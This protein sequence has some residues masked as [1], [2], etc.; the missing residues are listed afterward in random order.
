MKNLDLKRINVQEMNVNEMIDTDGGGIGAW[1]LEKAVELL[2]T[3][4]LTNPRDYVSKGHDT[5]LGH[6]GGARP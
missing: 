4:M 3:D 6:Y 5:P 2:L 1:L